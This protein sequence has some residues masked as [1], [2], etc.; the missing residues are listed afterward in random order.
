MELQKYN[1][2]IELLTHDQHK[3]ASDSFSFGESW[4]GKGKWFAKVDSNIDVTWHYDIAK[5]Q[6]IVTNVKIDM[7]RI[8]PNTKGGG[9]WDSVVFMNPSVFVPE[10]VG[11]FLPP[12]PD[13]PGINGDSLWQKIGAGNGKSGIFAFFTQNNATWNYSI[14]HSNNGIPFVAKNVGNGT[15]QLLSSVA[16]WN[17]GGKQTGHNEWS[18]EWGNDGTYITVQLPQPPKQPPVQEIHYHYIKTIFLSVIV[19][20]MTF[21][22]IFAFLSLNYFSSYSY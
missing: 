3:L 2:E 13:L 22:V 12:A 15:W 16:R 9:F 19:V 17:N 10:E 11:T 1:H 14:K 20:F 5:N 7:Q 18:V 8:D 6:V 4:L 21:Y